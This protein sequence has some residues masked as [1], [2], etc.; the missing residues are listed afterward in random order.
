D[1]LVTMELIRE[2]LQSRGYAVTDAAAN[3]DDALASIER[4]TPDLILMDIRIKGGLD[5]IELTRIVNE[6]YRVPVIYL[7]AFADRKTVERAKTAESYG[8]LIKPFGEMELVTNIEIALYKHRL[9]RRLRV[10]ENRYR[11]LFETMKDAVY[12]HDMSGKILDF[13]PALEAMFGYTS[14]EV[15]EINVRDVFVDPKDP[16]RFLDHIKANGFIKDF[17]TS[18]RRKDGEVIHC[19]MTANLERSPEDNR[20]IIRGVIRDITEVERSHRALREQQ[21]F[22]EAV[23]DSLPTVFYAVNREG[24]FVRWNR[25]LEELYGSSVDRMAG[26]NVFDVMNEK[27]RELFGKMLDEGFAGGT[28]T[29]E[30][31]L[32]QSGV[33]NEIRDFII[34]GRRVSIGGS[35]YLVGSGLDITERKSMEDAL[36]RGEEKYRTLVENLNDVIFTLDAA[37]TITYMSP[38]LQGISQYRVDEVIGRNFRELVHPDD[39][40][41][42]IRRLAKTIAGAN[43]SFEF[44]VLDKDGTVRHVR[45]S[46]RVVTSGGAVTGVTGVMADITDRKR[47]EE[48]VVESENRYRAIF[49]GSLNLVYIHDFKGNF[50][51]ANNAALALLGYARDDIPRLSFKDLVTVEDLERATAQIAGMIRTGNQTRIIEYNLRARSGE[52]RHIETSASLLYREG[53]PYAVLGVAR[54]IT[55]RKK[56]IDE[57]K[58]VSAD[59]ENLLN[60]ITSILIGVDTH[61]VITHWNHMAEETFRVP[62]SEAV[63]KKITGYDIDWE[64]DA[65]YSGISS[66]IIGNCPINL[67]DINYRDNNGKPGVL[68]IT[69]NP[70]KDENDALKGFLIH[71]KDI[72]EKRMVEQQLLQSSKM[73]TVGEMATGV[74][75]ELNQPLNVIKMASQ[76]LMD[77]LNEKYATEDFVRERVQKIVAQVDRAAHIINHLRE[78]G[79]KSDYDFSDIDPNLPIRVAF[80]MLGEQ[81]RINDIGVSLD[82]ADNLPP[83]RGDLSKLEQVFI[84]L[85]VNAKDAMLGAKN[86]LQEKNIMVKSYREQDGDDV[87]IRFGDTG[88]GMPADVAERIF[89]PFFTTKEV[90]KGTGLGLSISYGIIKAHRGTIDIVPGESG[91]VFHVRL[92]VSRKPGRMPEEE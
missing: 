70:I 63:G 28:V 11:S 24:R 62:S 36:R 60:S 57:L 82:L 77:G 58:R 29:F 53:T 41:E 67:T 8:Y 56:Y 50:I 75:H 30:T 35:D 91:A 61:D 23:L 47:M 89:E 64:W 7:T 18:L 87:V 9:D 32:R 40:P 76:Y 25:K 68:G 80:D 69:I 66:C 3:G 51:D 72:T 13:N 17:S 59:N 14:E 33:D 49:D 71:G 52:S 86:P 6:K 90:G 79:R 55:E 88:P 1:E 4:E 48:A 83:V 5:G 2:V 20:K 78:F 39:L 45:T 16:D 10:S 12:T 43:E 22:M 54:D 31:R 74:A 38:A 19:V 65:I 26:V 44:R 85:I 37:G 46:S 42:L 92:P 34:T 27:N 15:P 21:E 73:A 84:N 81:L